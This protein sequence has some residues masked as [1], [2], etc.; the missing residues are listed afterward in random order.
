[1]GHLMK[2]GNWDVPLVLQ[3]HIKAFQMFVFQLYTF[4]KN[5]SKLGAFHIRTMTSI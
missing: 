5:M 2:K 1:M 4:S 3:L